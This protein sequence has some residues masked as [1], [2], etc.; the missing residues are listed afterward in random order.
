MVFGLPKGMGA[1][2]FSKYDVYRVIVCVRFIGRG[3]KF[4]RGIGNWCGPRETCIIVL[5]MIF[6]VGW[7][8]LNQTLLLQVANGY[9]RD[10]SKEVQEDLVPVMTG[11]N[12][13]SPYQAP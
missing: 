8:R 4:G 10:L 12:E 6:V 3:V 1:S 13:S 5:L 7:G 9:V 11:L 2:S